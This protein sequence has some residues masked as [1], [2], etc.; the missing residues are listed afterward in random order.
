M[1]TTTPKKMTTIIDGITYDISDFLKNHPGG[2]DMLLL[3][4]DRDAS[5]LFHSYHKNITNPKA[6]L[7]KLPVVGGKYKPNTI[8]TPLYKTLKERVN[9]YFDDTKQIGRG[10]ELMWFKS[11]VLILLTAISYYFAIIQGYWFVCPILGIFMAINGLAIQHDANHGSFSKYPTLNRLASVVDD[12]IGGSSLIWRHQHIVIHHVCPNH[13]ELDGDSYSKFPVMRLNP[14]LPLTWYLRYQWIYGPFVLYSLMGLSYSLEDCTAFLSGKYLFAR[15]HPLRM[16]DHIIFWGGKIVHYLLFLG[17]PV[18]LH[19][20][21][22]IWML[23]V[24]LEVFGSNYLATLFAV[25]HNTMETD[26]NIPEDTDWAELQ[27]RTSANWSVHSTLWWLAS[28][29]LNYQIEH[30][31]FPGVCHVHYPAISKIVQEVCKE[32]KLPYNAYPTFSA[33][34]RDHLKALHKLGVWK[35]E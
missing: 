34:Y 2:E 30:H 11:A 3:A 33:I 32:N 35:Q 5:V 10:T 22:A 25:S 9:K 4:L 13:H 7:Q 28:G 12:V 27:I 31:L 1:V 23:Y 15:F 24:N 17:I 20:L 18:Y 16:L 26:Y 14:K 8:E 29:G 19:G 6:V 21:P